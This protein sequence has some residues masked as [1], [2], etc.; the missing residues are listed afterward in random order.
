[1]N[2]TPSTQPTVGVVG[3]GRMGMPIIGH[4]AKKGFPT[5][6]CDLDAGKRGRVVEHGARWAESPAEVAA[7][8]DR[9]P[10]LR[11]LRRRG[12]RAPG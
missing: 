6:A 7:A 2:P 9:D 3:A 10:R 11:R 8:A 5:L 12:S 1:M 4:L